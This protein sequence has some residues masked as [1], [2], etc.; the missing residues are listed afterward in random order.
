MPP[1]LSR[2][3]FDPFRR[4]ARQADPS[5]EDFTAIEETL[6]QIEP[7]EG[8]SEGALLQFGLGVLQ[9]LGS[10]DQIRDLG[11]GFLAK[12][13]ESEGQ[14]FARAIRGGATAAGQGIVR[15][16]AEQ[17]QF[18]R[19]E[20]LQSQERAFRSELAKQRERA[21]MRRLGIRVSSDRDLQTERL[22]A[23]DK[24]IQDRAKNRLAE[25]RASAKE[26]ITELMVKAKVDADKQLRSAVVSA[27]GAP[28][29]D[30]EGNF[31]PRATLD[32][33]TTLQRNNL[34]AVRRK[35][36][37]D[38]AKTA[39][40][41][42][43]IGNSIKRERPLTRQEK[44]DADTQANQVRSLM[45]KELPEIEGATQMIL[46]HEFNLIKSLAE[47]RVLNNEEIMNRVRQAVP[48]LDPNKQPKAGKRRAD[49]SQ[50]SVKDLAKEIID[51]A[52][53]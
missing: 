27:G 15:E 21:E 41:I 35:Q 13:P 36:R 47:L 17:Q 1:R 19:K 40:D 3:V 8:I 28:I 44:A 34:A 22:Q 29:E 6:S 9:N 53:R 32:T 51:Q 37:A 4:L 48:L 33:L 49:P 18:Q 31:L 20:D 39:A 24:R 38:I 42:R 45:E 10:Q 16:R 30:A 5:T 50:P 23:E 26:D 25:I 12:V 43:R 2:R 7:P 11:G 14:R 52:G 46:P